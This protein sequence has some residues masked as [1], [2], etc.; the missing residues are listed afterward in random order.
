MA[1]ETDWAYLGGLIDG[2]GCICISKPRS[3]YSIHQLSVRVSNTDARL[4]IW[5][6]DNFNG[7]ITTQHRKNKKH[8]DAYE[9]RV[10]A[11]DSE[12]IL[13]NILPYLVIKKEQALLALDLRHTIGAQGRKIPFFVIEYRNSLYNEMLKLNKRGR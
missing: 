5:L 9:W 8:K 11:K 1:A 4:M 6:K 2:E 10:F 3:S 12:Y 7:S 13:E